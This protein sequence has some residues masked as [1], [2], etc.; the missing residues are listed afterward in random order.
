MSNPN[1]AKG[2]ARERQA[3]ALLADLTGYPVRRR[4]GAGRADD[5]GDLDGIPDTVVQVAAWKDAL[6]AVWEKPEG[7]ERQR[8]NAAA[9][10]AATLVW[11]PRRGWRVVLT[12]EQYAAY[13][14]ATEQQTN[15]K[16]TP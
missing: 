10:Y 12:P 13:I 4:L 3:A 8:A 5:T 6:R 9:G 1:K 11:L 14:Q 7:A 2:D 15:R 16:D